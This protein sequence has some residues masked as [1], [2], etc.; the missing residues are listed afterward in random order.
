MEIN[1]HPQRIQSVE[2]VRIIAIFAVIIIHTMPFRDRD[3]YL[4]K[5]FTLGH[6]LNQI[7]RFAVPFFFVI[8]G[9]FWGS[10][11]NERSSLFETTKKIAKKIILIFLAWSV[12][13]LLPTNFIDPIRYGSI[14][15][16]KA[17]YLNMTGLSLHPM[18]T[19]MQGSK[20]HLWFMIS[21]LCSLG[22]SAI[23]IARGMKKSLI[24]LSV[25]LYVT[26][27][28]GKAYADTPIGFH[29]EY[30]LRNGP[31]FGLIFFVTG[32]L[33]SQSKQRNSW[34]FLGSLSAIFGFL[35]HFAEIFVLRSIW[36]TPVLQDYVIGTYFM[37]IGVALIALS[38]PGFLKSDRFSRIGQ[39]VLG[40]YAI[41]FLFVDML[42][43]LE[44]VLGTYI[45]WGFAYPITVFILSLT[46]TYAMSRLRGVKAIVA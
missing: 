28:L 5:D 1:P 13:Y 45:W 34:L 2:V 20:D 19:I 29:T 40:I 38:D 9:Y 43:P 18:T 35:L 16:V 6:V 8:S 22:I 31:F 10:K 24:G 15:P 26:G 4:G 27:L 42:R 17:A 44:R 36:S 23:F 21:L 14:S 7:A 3:I 41:H 46:S 12:I 30:N 39:L 37:G 11:I 25:M 33:L 32:Y